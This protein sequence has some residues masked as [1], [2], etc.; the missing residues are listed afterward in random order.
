MTTIRTSICTALVLALGLDT[1]A[2]AAPRIVL[3]YRKEIAAEEAALSVALR[4]AVERAVAGAEASIRE[5]LGSEFKVLGQARGSFT[6]AGAQETLYLLSRRAP[7]AADPSPGGTAQLVV[8]LDGEKLAGA[9][10]LPQ[11]TQYHTV[12]AALDSDGDGRAE[13]VLESSFYNMGQSVTSLDVVK[14]GADGA[15]EVRQTLKE[16]LYDGCDNPAGRK[17]RRASTISLDG[18]GSLV[19][20]EHVLPCR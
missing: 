15:T 20:K 8:A 9:Y 17:Q 2:L 4:Q 16:V 3:D 14:L 5:S 13:L 19:A 7:V 6:R 18:T 10:R 12:A 11:A 1:A